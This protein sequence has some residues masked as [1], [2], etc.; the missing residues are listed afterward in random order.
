[1][2][3][4]KKTATALVLGAIALAMVCGGPAL[5][6]INPAA[7]LRTLA[8]AKQ[9]THQFSR[10][11]AAQQVRDYLSTESGIDAA[12]DWCRKTAVTKVY[13]EVFPR[14]LP[15]Q[16]SGTPA[17]RAAVPGS[18]LRGFRVR[19][20][21]RHRQTVHGLECRLLLHGHAHPRAAPGDLQYYAAGMFDETMIDKFWFTDCR[22]PQCD[23]AQEARAL[24]TWGNRTYPVAGATAE[25]DAVRAASSPLGHVSRGR[26][27]RGP[28]PV[29]RWKPGHR[30]L[31]GRGRPRGTGRRDADRLPSRLAASLDAVDH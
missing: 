14:W 1:M 30:E 8:K 5:A 24:T 23:A 25:F 9:G 19:H 20:N 18:G 6:R 4:M 29:C 10:L 26:Q 27:S 21:H 31:Q 2:R 17:R 3:S 16:A 13:I 11:F 15:G 7:R 12:I 28:L 22:C